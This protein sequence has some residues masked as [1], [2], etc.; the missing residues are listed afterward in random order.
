MGADEAESKDRNT[1]YAYW[2]FSH[3]TIAQPTSI[4]AVDCHVDDVLFGNQTL[5]SVIPTAY[6]LTAATVSRT[7]SLITYHTQSTLAAVTQGV[8][9]TNIGH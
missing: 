8:E 5:S 6:S 3:N 4:T 9:F 1:L 7:L 2:L